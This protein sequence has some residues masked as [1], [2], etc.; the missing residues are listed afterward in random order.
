MSGLV[1]FMPDIGQMYILLHVPSSPN[2]PLEVRNAPSERFPAQLERDRVGKSLHKIAPALEDTRGC[3]RCVG[4]YLRGINGLSSASWTALMIAL[5]SVSGSESNGG[6]TVA[7]RSWTKTAGEKFELKLLRNNDG[8]SVDLLCP[9]EERVR[10]R[11]RRCV[12]T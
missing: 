12:L 7:P 10:R 1:R 5:R 6:K 11:E 3:E 8:D 2:G 4:M 9:H